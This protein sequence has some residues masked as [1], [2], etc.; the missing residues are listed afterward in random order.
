[1]AL[2]FN[3]PSRIARRP[4]SCL[5]LSQLTRTYSFA[6]SVA[7]LCSSPAA[8]TSHARS[9][10]SGAR[11]TSRPTAQLRVRL[12]LTRQRQ[13]G[14][15]RSDTNRNRNLNPPMR[16]VCP[17]FHKHE[18]TLLVRYPDTNAQH[19]NRV[20]EYLAS[21]IGDYVRFGICCICPH[22][23]CRASMNTIQFTAVLSCT[24]RIQWRRL[25]Q[26][27][28]SHERNKKHAVSFRP[29]LA[30][31]NGNCN[32]HST[33]GRTGVNNQILRVDMTSWRSFHKFRA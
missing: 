30:G 2:N 25:L 14:S 17:V 19:R 7:S 33:F 3:S 15:R 22:G 13:G 32:I 5:Y 28:E 9:S 1:M 26:H 4:P 24:H 20:L 8:S 16:R 12:P 27:I 21:G 10:I 18:A 31:T 6:P 29:C 11:T 23:Y